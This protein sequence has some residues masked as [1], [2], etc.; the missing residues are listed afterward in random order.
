[1]LACGTEIPES[2]FCTH[3]FLPLF[4]CFTPYLT[5]IKCNRCKDLKCTNSQLNT[6]FHNYSPNKKKE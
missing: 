4:C 3:F 1:M 5:A 6:I 2:Q